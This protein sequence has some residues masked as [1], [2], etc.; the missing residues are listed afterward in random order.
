VFSGLGVEAESV[1]PPG[2]LGYEP[3]L[4]GLGY[5]PEKARTL[6]RRAGY[7]AGFRVRYFRWDT[8]E[9]YNSGMVP[10]IIE[11]LSEIGIKVEVSE[12]SSE[13]AR[14]ARERKGHDLIG[15][16]NWYADFPDSDNFFYIFF[17]SAS[18]TILG[19]N[20]PEGKWDALIEEA[21]ST[22]DLDRRIE[23]Y[24]QLNRRSVD[25]APMVYLFHDRFFVAHKPEVRGLRTHLVPP[26]VRYHSIWIER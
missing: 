10:L 12:H 13:E 4:K 24:R 3:D 26:P 7:A 15:C 5:D 9:F 22:N 1:L 18:G 6:M 19:M 25:E 14:H 2:L 20:F 11:D 8:D 21:R 17:H 23:I 16:G